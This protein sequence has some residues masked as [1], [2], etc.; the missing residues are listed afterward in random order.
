MYNFPKGN[1]FCI[2]INIAEVSY[3]P[4]KSSLFRDMISEE[5]ERL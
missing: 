1:V 2:G 3:F 5:D 4:G